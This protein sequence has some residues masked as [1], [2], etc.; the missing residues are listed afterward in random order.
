MSTDQPDDE[1]PV[2]VAVRE[3]TV[4]VVAP[5]GADVLDPEPVGVEGAD[6]G[7][8][9]VAAEAVPPP[10]PALP[11]PPT[12]AGPTPA[13]SPGPTPSPSPRPSPTAPVPP[14]PPPDPAARAAAAALAVP[15]VAGL[16]GGAFGEIATHLPGRRVAGVRTRSTP[17]GSRIDVHVV[18]RLGGD[19]RE[20]ASVVHQRVHD[21]VGGQVHVVVADLVP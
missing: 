11:L 13:A 1:E 17:D 2:V 9:G 6:V 10:V 3:E 16:Y 5:Q 14:P 18:A 20:L 8:A 7:P 4:V 19:L 21:T 15:G 12:P